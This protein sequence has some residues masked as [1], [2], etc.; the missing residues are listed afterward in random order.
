[1]SLE[2]RAAGPVLDPPRARARARVA[3]PRLRR[4]SQLRRPPNRRLAVAV[5]IRRGPRDNLQ[6]GQ[7]RLRV[8]GG[9]PK[10]AGR[11]RRPWPAWVRVPAAQTLD[12]GSRFER[13]TGS[14]P[15]EGLPSVT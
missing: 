15:V 1:M 11:L 10:L 12:G 2:R 5:A 8:A 9:R 4:G 7:I 3:R 14:D 6:R 13:S